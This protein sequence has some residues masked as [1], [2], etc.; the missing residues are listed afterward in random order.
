M[1]ECFYG[2]NRDYWGLIKCVILFVEKSQKRQKNFQKFWK[3][4]KKGIDFATQKEKKKEPTNA[5]KRKWRTRN[6]K[7]TTFFFFEIFE[8]R[9]KEKRKGYL[10]H[11]A[12]TRTLSMQPIW[13]EIK[14]FKIDSLM[15]WNVTVPK[16]IIGKD[17]SDAITNPKR[18]DLHQS[19][20]KINQRDLCFQENREKQTSRK[21][22][23][24]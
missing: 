10:R 16:D 4:W 7:E 19:E 17:R 13:R 3:K 8:R 9:T 15:I 24:V 12:R 21:A 22:K 11:L 23:M 18:S 1:L 6:H 2:I 20:A 5:K 14:E